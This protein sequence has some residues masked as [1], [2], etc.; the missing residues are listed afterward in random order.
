MLSSCFDN[1]MT[2]YVLLERQNM[3]EQLASTVVDEK[4]DNR[5]DL[6]VF[7]SSV[8][9]F[10]Y[11]KNSINRCSLLT[12]GTTFFTLYVMSEKGASEKEASDASE[13]KVLFCGGSLQAM[14]LSGGDPPNPPCGRRGRTA[15]AC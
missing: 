2:P 10:V 4:T 6:P 11:M 8:N 9:L 13:K 7:T 15:Q 3:A 12:T 14:G 5:G 1:F